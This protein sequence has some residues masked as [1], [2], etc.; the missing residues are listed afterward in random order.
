MV[1][2]QTPSL[3]KVNYWFILTLIINLLAPLTNVAFAG[4]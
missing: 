4:R 2:N 1:K 3:I